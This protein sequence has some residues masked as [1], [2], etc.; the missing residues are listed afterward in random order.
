MPVV[1][2]SNYLA[3]GDSVSFGYREA[4][5]SP[6]PNY[7][8][9]ASFVAF[10][11]VVA[12]DLGLNLANLACPGETSGSLIHPRVPSNGCESDPGADGQSVPGGYRA[13]Y[14]LHV[15]YTGS[16]LAAAVANLKADPD[17]RLVTLMI[18]ADDLLLCLETTKD[19]C[20]SRSEQKAVLSHLGNNLETILKGL[21]ATGYRGQI[22]LVGY[23]SLNYNSPFWDGFSKR[24]N[25]VMQKVAA[26]FNAEYANGYAA[27]DA[28]SHF[29]GGDSCTAG[30]LTQWYTDGKLNGTCG[31][32]PSRAG[33]AVL[34]SVVD[35][36][37]IK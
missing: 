34:A 25:G 18:G 4:N 22:V 37:A 24:L 27:F 30:L 11:E 35:G 32:H 23:Y 36:T 9:A 19:K 10:P 29:S 26:A 5:T 33:A 28:A 8:D 15:K 21:R 14:P 13:A 6:A 1:A 31:V 12:S 20:A 2:G 7:E 16:Q 3:L 17:T